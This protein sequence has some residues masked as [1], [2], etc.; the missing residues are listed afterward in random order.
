MVMVGGWIS[1]VA[2]AVASVAFFLPWI[3]SYSGGVGI[4]MG[5]QSGYDFATS[6][7]SAASGWAMWPYSIVLIAAIVCL[8]LSIVLLRGGN[9]DRGLIAVQDVVA[10][11]GLVTFL[12]LRAEIGRWTGVVA[13]VRF[14]LVLT[15][16]GLV[17][18]I[19]GSIVAIGQYSVEHAGSHGGATP[20]SL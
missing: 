6:G 3:T 2:S 9:R 7:T 10:V 14:G 12:L 4:S 19:V 18:V 1:L 13:D 8:G 17:G 20:H 16:A 11:G 15:V 5:T